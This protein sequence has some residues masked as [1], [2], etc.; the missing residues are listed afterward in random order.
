MI[1]G[2][3]HP[4]PEHLLFIAPSQQ[5]IEAGEQVIEFGRWPFGTF[6]L[7]APRNNVWAARSQQ[8]PRFIA[9]AFGLHHAD[10]DFLFLIRGR[11]GIA[12]MSFVPACRADRHTTAQAVS[13]VFQSINLV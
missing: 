13:F 2:A 10:Q 1:S 3:L 9:F 7:I 11:R 4:H 6:Q 5:G 8:C 12:E